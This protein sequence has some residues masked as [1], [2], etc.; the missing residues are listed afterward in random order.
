VGNCETWRTFGNSCTGDSGCG[1]PD[2]YCIGI[3]SWACVTD[4]DC[5]PQSTGCTGGS[6]RM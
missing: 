3:C 6:C 5:P 2:N 1:G 4:D